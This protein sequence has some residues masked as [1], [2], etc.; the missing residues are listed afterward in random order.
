MKSNSGQSLVETLMVIPI[1]F[2]FLVG[3]LKIY[4]DEE[5]KIR[6]IRLISNMPYSDFFFS[7]KEKVFQ[8]WSDSNDSDSQILNQL[9]S[10]SLN[11]S[12]F[13]SSQNTKD[14]TFVESPKISSS[15]RPSFSIYIPEKNFQLENRGSLNSKNLSDLKSFLQNNFI[16]NSNYGCLFELNSE[17]CRNPKLIFFFNE[18]AKKSAKIQAGLCIAEATAKCVETAEAAPICEVGALAELFVSSQ[19]GTESE[20]C[21]MLNSSIKLIEKTIQ[22]RLL[23]TLLK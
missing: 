9:K 19:N 5:K 8:N 20:M 6:E 1:F 16:S 11:P 22:A 17:Q 3:I 18:K 7:E 4:K 14:G 23:M 10:A 13:W 2:V 21:P 15:L 12:L